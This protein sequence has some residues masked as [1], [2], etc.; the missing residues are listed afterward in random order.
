MTD[1]EKEDFLGSSTKHC[2]Q[3]AFGVSFITK[4]CSCP[5]SRQVFQYQ[6]GLV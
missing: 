6:S 3:I 4:S 1:M 2:V 5:S